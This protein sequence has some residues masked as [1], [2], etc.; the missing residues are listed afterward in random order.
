MK[1]LCIILA[2][3][4]FCS[5]KTKQV[6][7]TKIERVYDTIV[8]NER[9]KVNVPIHSFIEVPAECDTITN[10]LKPFKQHILSGPVKVF[11]GSKNGKLTAAVNI[12]SIK[13][14]AVSNFQ[15]TLVD[16]SETSE[17]I[18]TKY[19]VSSWCWWLLLYSILITVYIFRKQLFNL[20]SKGFPVLKSIGFLKRFI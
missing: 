3:V 15:R 9:V 7:I 16:K 2:L 5:C 11:I 10:E 4:L 14:V 18:I 13:Q 17:I 20:V 19:K 1:N 12:D 8:K 6:T